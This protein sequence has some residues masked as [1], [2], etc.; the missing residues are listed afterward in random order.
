MSFREVTAAPKTH[1]RCCE[2]NDPVS[3]SPAECSTCAPATSSSPSSPEVQWD[4]RAEALSTSTLL[5]F[6]VCMVL[7][8]VCGP[9]D[10]IPSL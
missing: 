4:K 8:S 10:L 2:Q 5:F 7:R 3:Q 9:Q 1:A 6:S